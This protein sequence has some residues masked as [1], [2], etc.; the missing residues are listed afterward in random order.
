MLVTFWLHS[1]HFCGDHL[2]EQVKVMLP[3]LGETGQKTRSRPG[4]LRN[5]AVGNDD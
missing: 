4:S 2:D 1:E 3:P 5:I